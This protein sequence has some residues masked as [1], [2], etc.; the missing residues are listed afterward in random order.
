[1]VIV[2]L[3]VKVVKSI[4]GNS[5]NTVAV[6]HATAKKRR[7]DGTTALI[8]LS[9]SSYTTQSL[10]SVSITN[11]TITSIHTRAVDSVRTAKTV[12]VGSRFLVESLQNNTLINSI[13]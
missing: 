13:N 11:V 4:L 12:Q 10:Q 9:Y 5:K 7:P 3:C 6:L 8:P 2:H 1:M